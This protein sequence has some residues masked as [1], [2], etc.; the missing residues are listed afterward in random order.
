MMAVAVI[1]AVLGI[2]K[3]LKKEDYPQDMAFDLVLFLMLAGVIGARIGYGYGFTA[4]TVY[5]MRF[6][7]GPLK[8]SHYAICTGFMALSMLLPGAVAGYLQQMLGYVGFFVLVMV[9][10]TA[11]IGVTLVAR[12]SS[13]INED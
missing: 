12:R 6:A 7:E 3:Q 2:G 13:C 1:V 9:C 10:C 11:T 4:Y 5:M 8:T